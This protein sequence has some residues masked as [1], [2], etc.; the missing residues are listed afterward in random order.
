MRFWFPHPPPFIPVF[1]P[2][3]GSVV[4]RGTRVSA[5]RIMYGFFGSCRNRIIIVMIPTNKRAVI[6]LDGFVS[7]LFY[8]GGGTI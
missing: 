2:P 1:H 3:K 5:A 4:K 8:L 7:I 6:F